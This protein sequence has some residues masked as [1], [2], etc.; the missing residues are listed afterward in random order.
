ME[1]S[2]GQFSSSLIEIKEVEKNKMPFFFAQINFLLVIMSI[3]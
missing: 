2:H 1:I 3:H